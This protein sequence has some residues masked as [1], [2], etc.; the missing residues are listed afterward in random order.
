YS[1]SKNSNI[2]FVHVMTV[3]RSS[4]HLFSGRGTPASRGVRRR[5]SLGALHEEDDEAH[6]DNEFEQ[7]PS[8]TSSSCYYKK[9][10]PP[11]ARGCSRSSRSI[12]RSSEN[13]ETSRTLSQTS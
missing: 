9:Y 4:Q 10:R 7:G 3:L 5:S 6:D 11:G 12:S 13:S 1:E 8:S 2:T